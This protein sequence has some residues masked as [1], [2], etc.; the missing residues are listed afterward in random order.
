MSIH[1]RRNL[2]AA[3]VCT[4][5]LADSGTAI[6]AGYAVGQDSVSGA[7]TAYAGGAAGAADASTVFANPA[8]MVKRRKTLIIL[9]LEVRTMF[10]DQGLCR[11]DVALCRSFQE[12]G[13]GGL[14][15]AF[16]V[17]EEVKHG[18]SFYIFLYE[19]AIRQ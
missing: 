17:E 10:R 3:L 6:A 5:A 16:R 4:L 15:L 2:L 19:R 1:S 7:G 11:L 14:C 9:G 18:R 8:G 13:R 12:Q